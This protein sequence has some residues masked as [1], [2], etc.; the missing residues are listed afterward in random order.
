[1]GDLQVEIHANLLCQCHIIASE[2]QHGE[3][4]IYGDT[5]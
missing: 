3:S 2:E 1:M 5:Y 4:N